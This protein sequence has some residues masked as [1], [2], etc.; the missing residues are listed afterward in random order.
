MSTKWE[1]VTLETLPGDQ[2]YSE[3]FNDHANMVLN[4]INGWQ[5]LDA[6]QLDQL[7]RK[8]ERLCNT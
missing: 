5:R 4:T 2:H 8:V 1:H 6:D 3:G 7:M